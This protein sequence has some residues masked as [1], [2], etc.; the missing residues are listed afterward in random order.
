L[1]A[2]E[3]KLAPMNPKSVLGRG[4]SITSSK[5]TQKIVAGLGDVEIE[6][7]LITELADQNFIES[8]V[9]NKQNSKETD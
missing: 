9:T 4:Y 3:N 5:S 7:I 1:T 8:R 6:D 2:V